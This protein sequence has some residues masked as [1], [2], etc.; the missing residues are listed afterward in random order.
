MDANGF[1]ISGSSIFGTSIF[2]GWNAG[3]SSTLFLGFFKICVLGGV[4]SSFSTNGSPINLPELEVLHLNDTGFSQ[5]NQLAHL[6]K[7]KQLYLKKNGIDQSSG[8]DPLLGL[9]SL[10]SLE[11][12]EVAS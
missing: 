3:G 2:G 11:H 10:V 4:S 9:E 8:T 5:M 1:F 6:G 12:L 7:L